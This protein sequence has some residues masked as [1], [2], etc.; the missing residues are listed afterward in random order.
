MPWACPSGDGCREP[1]SG[2]ARLRPY[3]AFI[4]T[5]LALRGRRAP[6]AMDNTKV[7]ICPCWGLRGYHLTCLQNVSSVSRRRSM[8]ER[9]EPCEFRRLPTT[10]KTAKTGIRLNLSRRYKKPLADGEVS[11]SQLQRFVTNSVKSS[12]GTTAQAALAIP[13]SFLTAQA[14]MQATNHNAKSVVTWI[15]QDF[16]CR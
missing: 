14:P 2:I 13:I 9:C 5:T 15:Y 16:R 10:S 6:L 12:H 7:S 4:L 11:R 8:G 1:Q 3:R